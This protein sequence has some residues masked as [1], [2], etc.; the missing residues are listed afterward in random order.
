M[1]NIIVINVSTAGETWNWMIATI[2]SEDA[3]T[4]ILYVIAVLVAA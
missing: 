4:T 1:A 2:S 3:R